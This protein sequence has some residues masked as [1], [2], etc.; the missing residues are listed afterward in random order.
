MY[1]EIK[2]LYNTLEANK[3]TC[4]RQKVKFPNNFPFLIVFFFVCFFFL[5]YL[6]SEYKKNGEKKSRKDK[7]RRS[8]FLS[9]IYTK[10]SL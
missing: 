1:F 5:D 7:T 3:L 8:P 4:R 9:F 10:L 2:Y 6:K